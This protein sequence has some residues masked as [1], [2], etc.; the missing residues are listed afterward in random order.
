[1]NAAGFRRAAVAA[2]AGPAPASYDVD[3]AFMHIEQNRH[4]RGI[5]AL[6]PGTSVASVTQVRFGRTPRAAVRRKSAM[7]SS[8]RPGTRDW[9]CCWDARVS[10][11]GW[12]GDTVRSAVGAAGRRERPDRL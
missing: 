5:H 7:I 10:G 2:G 3:A 11:A 12:A 9:R 8:S 6:W 1:M 4:E